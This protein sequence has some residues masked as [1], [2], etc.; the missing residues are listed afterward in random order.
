MFW[1]NLI[2]LFA[3]ISTLILF[4]FYIIGHIYKIKQIKSVLSEA[5]QFE[6]SF[7]FNGQKPKHFF[8]VSKGIGKIFSVSSLVGIKEMHIFNIKQLKDEFGFEKGTNVGKLT[9]IKPN[10][11]AYIR[12][13]VLDLYEGCFIELEKYDGIVISFG[14]A[15][16]GYDGSLIQTKYSLKMTI[17]S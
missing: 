1:L 11:K 16:S 14:I 12:V 10:E 4:V 17:K 2:S 15:A 6:D 9:D 13:D 3:S 5:Y 8:E 7:D